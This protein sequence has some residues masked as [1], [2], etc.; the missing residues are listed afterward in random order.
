MMKRFILYVCA[1]VLSGMVLSV[2]QVQDISAD[3]LLNNLKTE[4][5]SGKP[6]DLD[7]Q[8]TGI[9]T[10]I[11]HLEKSSGLSIELSPSIPL[12]SAVKGT[13]RYKQVPWDQIFA[14]VLKE[15]GLEAVLK[16]KTVL[17][18]HLQGDLLSIR[19]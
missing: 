1:L 6:I 5:Y 3:E 9:E 17:G 2:A 4:H 14:L 19:T 16:D 10:L 15:F 7:L 18:K 8:E 12:Q 11:S 13:Y